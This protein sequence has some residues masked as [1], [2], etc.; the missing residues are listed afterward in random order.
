MSNTLTSFSRRLTTRRTVFKGT[1]CN[2]ILRY[3]CRRLTR[4]SWGSAVDLLQS[5]YNSTILN[6]L[7]LNEPVTDSCST[8]NGFPSAETPYVFN[9]DFVDRGKESIEILL[10]LFAFLLLF[11]HDV[12]LNRGNHEDHIVNLR[13]RWYGSNQ[14]PTL[15]LWATNSVRNGSDRMSIL[16]WKI[17]FSCRYGFT[18]EVLGKYQVSWPSTADR[19]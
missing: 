11:P 9:G 16:K 12:H 13:C 8:Q 15:Y 5:Q 3:S 6:S 18:K 14:S 19:L 4:P 1:T 7:R 10:V 17:L 2:L